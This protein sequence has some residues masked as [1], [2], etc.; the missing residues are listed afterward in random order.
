M[1]TRVFK[2]DAAQRL[3]QQTLG[4]MPQLQQRISMALQRHHEVIVQM[5]TMDVWI[6]EQPAK[7]GVATL[8]LTGL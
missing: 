8:R 3:V 5:D 6:S 4:E 2:G 7:S 1:S